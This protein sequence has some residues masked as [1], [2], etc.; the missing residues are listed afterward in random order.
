MARFVMIVVATFLLV[1]VVMVVV[2]PAPMTMFVFSARQV[3]G[4][5]VRI[6]TTMYSRCPAFQRTAW[7]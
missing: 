4:D 7:C 6:S 3:A 5:R 1:M 2:M